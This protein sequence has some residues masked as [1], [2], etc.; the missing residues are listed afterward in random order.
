MAPEARM[1]LKKKGKKKLMAGICRA[2]WANNDNQSAAVGREQSGENEWEGSEE[3]LRAAGKETSRVGRRTSGSSAPDYFCHPRL[4]TIPSSPPCPSLVF[5]PCPF[6]YFH[7]SRPQP[8][9]LLMPAVPLMR[10]TPL[11]PTSTARSK[12]P[13]LTLLRLWQNPAALSNSSS[14]NVQLWKRGFPVPS[15]TCHRSGGSPLNSC[16]TSS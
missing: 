3:W 8:H 16:V 7:A 14:A 1:S 13:K 2:E 11:S 4:A 10:A 6:S 5:P 9:L 15:R 12:Q